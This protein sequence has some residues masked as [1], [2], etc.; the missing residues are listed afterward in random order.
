M[1]KKITSFTGLRFI[2]MSAIIINHLFYLSYNDRIGTVYSNFF[3][4]PLVAVNFFFILSGFGMMFSNLKKIPENE[5]HFPSFKDNI[6]YAVSHIKKLYPLYIIS[7]ITGLLI[8]IVSKLLKAEITPS[9]F[10]KEAIRLAINAL[11]LQS[12]SGM[13][14]FT[15]AYNGVSWFFS[16]LFCIYLVS[17]FFI[18]ILRK[19]SKSIFHDIA[20]IVIN[21]FVISLLFIVFG[22]I[23][24]FLQSKPIPEVDMLV[25]GSPYIRL[26]Y[27]LIGMNLALL[28]DK[29]QKS[30]S[31][32]TVRN[33][34]LYEIVIAL[35]ALLYYFT[36]NYI[37]PKY[38]D[39]RNIIDIII[40]SLIILIFSFDSGI[41]SRL[42]QSK[43]FQSLG[44]ISMYLYIIHSILI[45][46]LPLIF[47]ESIK[48]WSL[49][50]MVCYSIL[51]LIITFCLSFIIHHH[52][53]KKQI[54]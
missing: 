1:I 39:Y 10:V 24:V 50:F 31:N 33:I 48:S 14:F 15:H 19:I 53:T 25:Y 38:F 18:V 51:A 46:Q 35:L 7:I 43:V 40:P 44:E 37:V 20:F 41:V 23:E 29:I 13:T 36:R 17:P 11:L 2:M 9:F 4:N 45:L 54:S 21:L 22:K 42:L 27:V 49:S 8:L 28:C 5:M 34:S 26:F 6:K 30:K 16:S 52:N 3:Q 32:K 47:E 12:A